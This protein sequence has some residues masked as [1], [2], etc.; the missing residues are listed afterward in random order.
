LTEEIWSHLTVRLPCDI[1]ESLKRG[2][3][4]S[5]HNLES[6]RRFDSQII[7]DISSIFQEFQSKSIRLLDRGSREGFGSSDFHKKCD[8]IGNTLTLRESSKHHIFGGYTPCVWDSTSGNV[9]DQ[10][11]QSFV[12]TLKNPHNRAARKFAV[13]AGNRAIYCAK[14]DGPSFDVDICI[15]D[16]VIPEVTMLSISSILIGMIQVFMIKLSLTVLINTQY[17]K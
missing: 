2:R 8:G 10:S 4:I 9:Y 15:R 3:F 16:G 11:C 6:S 1:D 5:E 14:T 7:Y 17:A 13:V 12:Y